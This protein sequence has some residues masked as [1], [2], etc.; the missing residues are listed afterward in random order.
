MTF[1]RVRLSRPL[2]LAT[3]AAAAL[4][5]AAAVVHAQPNE[6]QEPRTRFRDRYRT[7]QQ[8]QR[9][10]ENVRKW[11]SEDPDERLEAVTGFGAVQDPKA[12]EYLLTAAND[13]D[14]RIRVKAIDVLGQVQ[15]KEAVPFLVQRLFMRDTDLGTKQRCLASL[16][17]IGD[18]R[19]TKPILDFLSRDVETPVRG[20]AI[21]A[22]GDI[23]DPAAL[24]ALEHLAQNDPDPTLRALANEAIRRIKAKPAP[25]VIPPALVDRRREAPPNP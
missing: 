25:P 9:L 17:R 24:P 20:N 23:G 3:T 7:P 8:N 4:L 1:P 11:K 21:Y 12:V 19:A 15:A 5:V 18:P 22:L 6:V 13:P 16:G 14:T 10:D 2:V